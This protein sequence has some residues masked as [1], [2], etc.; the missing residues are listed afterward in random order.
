MSMGSEYIPLKAFGH[1]N[2][3]VRNKGE[4]GEELA[5]DG[6]LLAIV[7]LLPPRELVPLALVLGRVG[8]AL[9]P[10]HDDETQLSAASGR[11]IRRRNYARRAAATR[12]ID[13]E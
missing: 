9:G 13:S 3:H 7:E 1:G 4:N 6:Q 8:C 12:R 5:R 10:V 11:G 2:K